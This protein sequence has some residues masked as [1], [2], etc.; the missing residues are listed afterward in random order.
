MEAW[1]KIGQTE[2]VT[3]TIGARRRRCFGTSHTWR[4]Q[5]ESDSYKP[6]NIT[7][8]SQEAGCDS[9]GST[10]LKAQSAPHPHPWSTTTTT[11]SSGNRKSRPNVNQSWGGAPVLPLCVVWHSKWMW[12]TVKVRRH[13][14]FM[15]SL[16][17]LPRHHLQRQLDLQ[18]Y[19]A[20]RFP[21]SRLPGSLGTR[22]ADIVL[23]GLT[24]H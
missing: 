14:W 12:R 10:L 21:S 20:Q 8:V 22:S 6:Q 24:R 4:F 5:L 7:H 13:R 9:P 15:S 17:F 2:G 23:S 1:F 11:L 19:V 18:P 3:A 16:L